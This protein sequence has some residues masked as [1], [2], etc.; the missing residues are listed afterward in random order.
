MSQQPEGAPPQ[1]VEELKSRLRTRRNRAAFYLPAG[2]IGIELTAAYEYLNG[3]E[4]DINTVLGAAA[5]V[6]SI[7]LGSY[8]L[9][10]YILIRE[11]LRK[12]K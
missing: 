11:E 1:D 6:G 7:C 4:I 3:Y 2:F 8:N 10:R 9:A 5:G 12:K